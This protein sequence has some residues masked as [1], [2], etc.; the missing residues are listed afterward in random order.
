ME[1]V[2]I[3]DIFNNEI[4]GVCRKGW[5]KK[6]AQNH[7]GNLYDECVERDT[8]IKAKPYGEGWAYYITPTKSTWALITT[9]EY[10]KINSLKTIDKVKGK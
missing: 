3:L 4:R 2:F 8:A 10:G 1:Y 9:D 7:Q 6:I 5:L